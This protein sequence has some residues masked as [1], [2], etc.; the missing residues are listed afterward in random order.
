MKT[1]IN[2]AHIIVICGDSNHYQVYIDFLTSLKRIDYQNYDITM[3]VLN[4]LIP[5]LRVSSDADIIFVALDKCPT[6]C[7]EIDKMFLEHVSTLYEKNEK[8]FPYEGI[9]CLVKLTECCLQ[10]PAET[11]FANIIIGASSFIYEF[12]DATTEK[13]PLKS[14]SQEMRQVLGIYRNPDSRLFSTFTDSPS[15]LAFQSHLLTN[16]PPAYYKKIVQLLDADKISLYFPIILGVDDVK[17]R[18]FGTKRS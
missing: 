2:K 3:F 15:V 18:Y 11:I 12:Y 1:M 4:D 14:F 8:K 13:I 7:S 16:R 17:F 6:S 10:L 5:Q 9:F